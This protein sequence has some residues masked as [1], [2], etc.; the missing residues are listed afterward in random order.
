MLQDRRESI[1]RG[2]RAFLGP[3]S[4]TESQGARGVEAIREPPRSARGESWFPPETW[5][6]NPAS[7]SWPHQPREPELGQVTGLRGGRREKQQGSVPARGRWSRGPALEHLGR[8]ATQPM[9]N[10]LRGAPMRRG[11]AKKQDGATH[12]SQRSAS[13]ERGRGSGTKPGEREA[14]SPAAPE[15]PFP[16]SGEASLQVPPE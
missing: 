1:Q 9:K 14:G 16:A 7:K 8:K 10:R 15:S 6:G 11:A 13:S 3:V 12:C 4:L 2:K 5:E